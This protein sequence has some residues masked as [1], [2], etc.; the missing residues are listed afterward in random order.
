MPAAGR[1]PLGCPRIRPRTALPRLG[2]ELR[3]GLRV[4]FPFPTRLVY[5]CLPATPSGIEIIHFGL[6]QE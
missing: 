4:P 2:K 3:A 1:Q 6:A 5:G